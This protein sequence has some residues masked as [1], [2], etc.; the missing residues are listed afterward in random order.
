[1]YCRDGVFNIDEVLSVV[2]DEQRKGLQSRLKK[3]GKEH[4]STGKDY[5]AIVGHTF[6][7]R[8]VKMDSL[9]YQTFKL[10]GTTCVCCG[11]KASYFALEAFTHDAKN[12]G[13]YHFNLYGLRNG[14]EVMFTKDHIEPKSKGGKDVIANMQTMCS[15]CNFEKGNK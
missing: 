9:R 12:G 13:P 1:M 14:K 6:N 10:K 5:L 11:L 2:V 7:G 4:G 8:V 3:A 15:D